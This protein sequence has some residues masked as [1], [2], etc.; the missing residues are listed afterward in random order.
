MTLA[1]QLEET[2]EELKKLRDACEPGEQKSQLRE[3]LNDVLDR[4]AIL[5]GKNIDERTAVYQEATGAIVAAN[6]AIKEARQ[7]IAKVAGTIEKV[8]KGLAAAQKVAAA[9]A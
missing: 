7:D 3:Q 5:T 4:I 1:E 6:A 8:A 2:K 9:V